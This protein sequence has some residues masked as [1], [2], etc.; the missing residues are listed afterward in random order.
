MNASDSKVRLVNSFLRLLLRF[1]GVDR[2][3]VLMKYFG[4]VSVLRNQ[5]EIFPAPR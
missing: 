3:T 5:K 4:F 2:Y 1:G